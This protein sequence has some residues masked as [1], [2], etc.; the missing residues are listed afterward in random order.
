MRHRSIWKFASGLVLVATAGLA[1]PP[2]I[3]QNGIVLENAWARRAPMMAPGGHGSPGAAGM[4]GHGGMAGH[5]TMG[6]GAAYVTIHNQGATPD[7]LVRA[8]SDAAHTVEL[9]EVVN[10]GGV[11]RM[12]PIEKLPIPPGATVRLEPGGYH[13]MLLGLTRDLK[14]G[15]TV[16]V[17]LTF[18]RAGTITVAAPIR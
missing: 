4:S 1:A 6:N 16:T 3:A 17:D 13:V 12:R 7:A 9:H 5:E 10:D 14:P 11:M 2:A 8:T 15:E 18:E